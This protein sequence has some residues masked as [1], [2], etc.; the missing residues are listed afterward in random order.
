LS[1]PQ[2]L[3]ERVAFETTRRREYW[4]EKGLEQRFGLP[5]RLWALA[6]VKELIDNA[7]DACEMAAI[8]PETAVTLADDYVIVEDNGTGIREETVLSSLN[9]DVIKSSKHHYLSPT[10]G[11]LGNA[12]KCVYAAPYVFTGSGR[13]E[14]DT[15]GKRFNITA[16]PDNLEQE[17]SLPCTTKPSKRKGGTAVTIHWKNIANSEST[18]DGQD[19]VLVFALHHLIRDFIVLNPHASFKLTT[20]SGNL[21]RAASDTSWEKWR[22]SG[23][24]AGSPH[25]YT[26]EELQGLIRALITSGQQRSSLRDFIGTFHGLTGSKHQK[27]VMELSGLR[28]VSYLDDMMADK[29][30]D[31][32]KTT[33]LLVAMRN[34]AKTV[35]P[36]RL[37][38]LGKERMT[39]AMYLHDVAEQDVKYK[40]EADIEYGLPYV[41]EA[42]FGVKDTDDHRDL[43]LGLNYSPALKVS[44]QLSEKLAEYKIE[45]EDPVVLAVNIVCPK[46]RFTSSDKNTVYFFDQMEKSITK[47]LKAVTSTFVKAKD[48]T[49]NA[50][51]DELRGA[52]QKSK[53]SIKTIAWDVM[54]DAYMKASANNT[55]PANARQIMYAARPL[56][57]EKGVESFDDK[58]FQRILKD[59]LIAKKER[60]RELGWDVVYDARGHLV[61]PHGRSRLGLG[62]VEV[63]NYIDGWNANTAG[64]DVAIDEL[65]PTVGPRDRYKFALFIEKEGFDSLLLR[66]EIA[67]R[68]DLAVFSSKGQSTTATR[69]LVDKLSQ[70]GVT[71]LVAHDF[72]KSGIEILYKL[73]HGEEDDA[74][75]FEKQPK[76]ANLGLSLED[77]NGMDL[78]FESV[79]ITQ[80]KDPR[81]TLLEYGATPEEADFLAGEKVTHKRGGKEHL[82]WRAKRVELNAM[83]SER[84]VGWIERKL[85]ENGVTKV[86]PD[87]ATLAAA[88]QRAD[89]VSRIKAA[90]AKIESAAI[91]VPVPDDLKTQV[92]DLLRMEP[93]LSWDE[94]LAHIA[95]QVK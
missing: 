20:P 40:I 24:N 51:R 93:S 45:A 25:W 43:L 48:R 57:L 69:L 33:Q 56:I 66:A 80:D 68:Y 12:L 17:P 95:A 46:L 35:A 27:E 28:G 7:L 63:R 94:A 9:Y 61:E 76:V 58:Y 4:S 52:K 87:E 38:V 18:Y 15:A 37:G 75:E 81:I 84:F 73:W 32:T 82:E 90:I 36:Q 44:H 83:T 59:Y 16:S 50:T 49:P 88:W 21:S 54:E 74:Y 60:V 42:A 79:T 67:K 14:I 23:Q 71:I 62:T 41:I 13:I 8:T 10:R 47:A 72:D 92:R 31:E 6:V 34:R 19:K 30:I 85:E 2:L 86:V 65:Y 1:A 53:D 39:D 5:K 70:A 22:S 64:L 55:L 11:Q 91:E 78:E 3:K 89:R 26:T 77:V 29:T